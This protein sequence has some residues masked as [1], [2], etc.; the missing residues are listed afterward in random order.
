M[1]KENDMEKAS[2][3]NSLDS[4]YRLEQDFYVHNYISQDTNM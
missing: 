1:S 4:N 3:S 2:R